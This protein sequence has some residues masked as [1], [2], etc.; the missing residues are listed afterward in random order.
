MPMTNG[1]T[2]ETLRSLIERALDLEAIDE[3]LYRSSSAQLW[4][5]LRARGVFGGQIIGLALSAA[6]RTVNERFLVHSF[7]CYFLL[8]GDNKV[9]IVFS[10]DRTRD[11]KTFATRSVR[12]KQNG[13]VIFTC[14]CSFQVPEDSILNHQYPMPVVPPPEELPNNEEILRKWLADPAT[15][16][17]SSRFLEMRLQEALPIEFKPCRPQ[18]RRDY[19]APEKMTDPKQMVWMRAR[20][21]LPDTLPFHQCVAAYTSD[22][23]LLNTSLLAHGVTG[24]TDPQLSM[25]ASLDHA[26][27]FHA[28]FRADDWLLYVMEELQ[29]LGRDPPSS[30]SAGP[31]GDD[32]FHWQATIMGPSDSPYSG[33][34][35]FLSIHFPT[36]YPF[37]P[38]KLIFT[39]RIYHP[40]INSNG[41]ICLD[42]LRDQWSPALTISKVLLSICS[43]LTDPNPDD[44]LVPEIAHV[45]K[46]DRAR[47]EATAREWTRKYAM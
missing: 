3:N 41:S 38:P 25:I 37:K 19:F 39:T 26:I 2:S 47:Y 35:F 31:V 40:N 44:P 27:W 42:I 34:V 20:G 10:V 4:K 30:C 28:P 45:Y 29:D 36:D 12:A 32:L 11:G 17:Q 23:Y 46:T 8:A 6:T 5:P 1:T 24:F 22:H 43:L 7:H 18:R 15:P 16:P 9:P 13:K 33:G 21:N 14:M